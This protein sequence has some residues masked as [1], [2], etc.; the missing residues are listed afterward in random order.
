M[1]SA[2]EAKRSHVQ[3][4]S[5]RGFDIDSICSISGYRRDFCLRWVER[6]QGGEGYRSRPVP[7]RPRKLTIRH[8]RTLLKLADGKL[9]TSVRKLVD[10]LKRKCKISIGRETIR[11]YLRKNKL[12]SWKRCKKPLLSPQN[13]RKRLRFA[14]KYLRSRFK[15][16]RPIVFSD[17]V[18][19]Q[20]NGSPNSSHNRVWAKR[21]QD[22]PIV[23]T[24]YKAKTVRMWGALLPD[25]RVYYEFYSGTLNAAKYIQIIQRFDDEFKRRFPGQEYLLQQD[26]ASCHSAKQTARWFNQRGIHFISS[27]R[28]AKSEWP[29]YSPDLNPIEHLWTCKSRVYSREPQTLDDLQNLVERC[30]QKTKPAYVQTLRDSFYRR[31]EAVIKAQ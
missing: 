30:M 21:R 2:R 7:G 8:E 19:F 12:R 25:N 1:L 22:V 13:V 23:R 11:R 6:L 28:S 29:P 15:V 26:G 4:L 14:K 24:V 18:H 27:G 20:L 3:M 31:L 9:Y 17:E 10:I 5:Q 16:R